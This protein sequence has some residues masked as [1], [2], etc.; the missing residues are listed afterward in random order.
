MINGA[1]CNGQHMSG[2]GQTPATA[3]AGF[4]AIFVAVDPLTN[5]VYAV[6]GQDN[7]VTTINGNSCNGENSGGVRPRREPEPSSATNRP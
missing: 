1:I 2:C 4:G 6:N 7:S 3:P 5:E